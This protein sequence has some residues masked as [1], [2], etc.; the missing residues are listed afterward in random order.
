MKYCSQRLKD[1]AKVFNGKTPSKAEQRTN[2]HP[3]LKIRDISEEG[4]FV[5]KFDSFVDDT[6][7]KSFKHKCIESGDTL[8]LNAAHNSE[9]VGSKQYYAEDQVVGSIPT[10]EW[11][12][13]RPN[14]RIAHPS[15]VKY[16]LYSPSTRFQIKKIVKGIHLY[17]KDVENLGIPVPSL[18][19]QKRIAAI[20]DKADAIRR[21]RQQ[22]IKLADD[23]LRATFLDMFGDPI[24]NPKGWDLKPLNHYASFENGDR[25]SNYPSGDDIKEQGVLFVSTKNI[26]N[27]TFTL[28]EAKFITEE[29]FA[30]LSRGKLKK[31]DL[32]I[33][34]R[35]TLGSCC[36][37]DAAYETGF[38]NAQM[39]I[40]RPKRN[41][42]NLF[43]HAML[44]SKPMQENFQNIGQGAAV[45]QLTG[46]QISDLELPFP[47]IE[48]QERFASILKRTTRL[49]GKMNHKD[50]EYLFQSLTQSAFRGEI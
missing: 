45:P 40:I 42:N 24:I 31:G 35:G 21:K 1:I 33:T 44:T 16:W 28:D 18:S 27:N 22:A 6:F 37:F 12:L 36:I 8:I 19:E 50:E 13:V 17:P 29:K 14:D 10:G 9:Y 49:R 32:I 23:F 25:S 26:S 46:K 48:I 11:L 5:G 15:F 3:V 38:I 41:C 39:M 34:L 30:S 43:L 7:L 4:S 47:P 20:L 2:G